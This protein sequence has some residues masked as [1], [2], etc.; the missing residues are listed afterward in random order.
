VPELGSLGTVRGAL[1]DGR[2][3][4]EP[5]RGLAA[6]EKQRKRARN[7][8]L[9]SQFPTHPSRE[10]FAA[11]QGI[12]SGDQGSFRRDQGIPPSS[13]IWHSL[14]VTNPIVLTDFERCREG[15]HGRRQM[16]EVAEADRDLN[17]GFCPCERRARHAGNRSPSLSP[18][19]DRAFRASRRRRGSRRAPP[20]APSSTAAGGPRVRIHLPPA[21]SLVRT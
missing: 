10:F 12:K 6:P 8:F 3:Y 1:G 11:L 21:E 16:L 2:P 14:P 9:T 18:R 15:E 13:A 4:R 17:A 19:T 7:Q 5:I 20:A